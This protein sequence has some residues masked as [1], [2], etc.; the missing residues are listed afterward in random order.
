VLD[1]LRLTLLSKSFGLSRM[2]WNDA[3][4]GPSTTASNVGPIRWMSPESLQYRQYSE[5]SD[6][7]MFGATIVECISRREPHHDMPSFEVG[8]KTIMRTQRP[9][10][11]DGT[12]PAMAPIIDSCFGWE[13]IERP[14]FAQIVAQLSPQ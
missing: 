9:C 6:V 5:K 7:W 2:T 4:S 3:D 13:P 12:P 8:T 10:S 1:C 14:S 11:P